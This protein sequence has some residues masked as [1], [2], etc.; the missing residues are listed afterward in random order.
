MAIRTAHVPHAPSFE[1]TKR[2][3]LKVPHGGTLTSTDLAV[4]RC[5][6]D[7]YLSQPAM[8]TVLKI[9]LYYESLTRFE[10]TTSPYIYPRYGLGELPQVWS[11]RALAAHGLSMG[12]ICLSM[13]S[14]AF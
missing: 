4:A 10:G 9:K 6:D 3:C 2:C 13:S 1:S 14:H 8:D 12:R 11:A 5:R 7:G